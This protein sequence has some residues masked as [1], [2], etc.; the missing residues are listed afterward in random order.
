MGEKAAKSRD[1]FVVICVILSNEGLRG[2]GGRDSASVEKLVPLVGHSPGRCAE[3][4]KARSGLQRLPGAPWA[5]SAPVR[6]R[7]VVHCAPPSGAVP[8]ATWPGDQ[9]LSFRP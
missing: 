1:V 7:P 6:G 3:R 9:A 8:Q 2:S 5:P 4:G